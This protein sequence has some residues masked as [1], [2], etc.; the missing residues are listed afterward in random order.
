[1]S[2]FVSISNPLAYSVQAHLRKGAK[3]VSLEENYRQP[4]S[5]GKRARCETLSDKVT[6]SAEAR[7]PTKEKIR[8]RYTIVPAP[9][10]IEPNTIKYLRPTERRCA[11]NMSLMQAIKRVK[12]LPMHTPLASLIFHSFPLFPPSTPSLITTLPHAFSASCQLVL[13]PSTSL[14]GNSCAVQ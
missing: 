6:S 2:R 12:Q 9:L 10:G 7:S 4:H 11:V 5:H 1:M 3:A 13:V 14:T 8:N